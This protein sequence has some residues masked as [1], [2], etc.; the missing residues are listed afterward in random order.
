MLQQAIA[1]E[2]ANLPGGNVASGLQQL[3]VRTLGEYKSIEQIANTVITTVDQ[4]PIRVK[5]VA[6]VSFGYQD[7]NRLVSIDN[8]PMIRFGIRKQT[9]ANTVAVAQDIRDQVERI[10]RERKDMTLFVTTDQS[11]FIQSSIDNV[12]NAAVWGA[13]TRGFC[14]VYFLQKRI[15]NLHYSTGN[16]NFHHCHVCPPLLQ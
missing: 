13:F 10:N 11:D 3:Y 2:N 15:I 14:T 16:S 1:R 8:K 9:G 7:L 6:E 12:Q 5:D 4:Q